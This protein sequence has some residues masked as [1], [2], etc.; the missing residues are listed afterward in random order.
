MEDIYKKWKKLNEDTYKCILNLNFKVLNNI[1]Y[2]EWINF[3][4]NNEMI[5]ENIIDNIQILAENIGFCIGMELYNDNYDFLNNNY[6]INDELYIISGDK[7]ILHLVKWKYINKETF[8]LRYS[9]F[10]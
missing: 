9:A 10:G 6:L 8:I 4:S 5:D 1:T 3:E 7:T 2:N